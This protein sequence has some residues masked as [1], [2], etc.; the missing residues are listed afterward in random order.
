MYPSSPCSIAP[1]PDPLPSPGNASADI[2]SALSPSILTPGPHLVLSA[3]FLTTPSPLQQVLPLKPSAWR[4]QM[5]L[6]LSESAPHSVSALQ[7]LGWRSHTQADIPVFIVDLVSK[8]RGVNDSQLHLD[9]TFLDHWGVNREGTRGSLLQ[10]TPGVPLP[11][12]WGRPGLLTSTGP[13]TGKIKF[14]VLN[15][16]TPLFM[17]FP[18]PGMPSLPLCLFKS[19]Q[20]WDFSGGPVAKTPCSQCREAQV[21]LLVRELGLQT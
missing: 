9:T 3:C 6:S 2:P 18:A 7:S 8:A 19:T 4:A 10:L 1:A 5:V 12:S 20:S 15:T 16:S 14:R 11:T 17:L 13:M 21:Q